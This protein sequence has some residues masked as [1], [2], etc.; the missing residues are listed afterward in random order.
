MQ[1]VFK[2]GMV[3]SRQ[4]LMTNTKRE[5][6]TYKTMFYIIKDMS[7]PK[8]FKVHD[9]LNNEME[10]LPPRHLVPYWIQKDDYLGVQD[11]IVKVLEFNHRLGEGSPFCITIEYIDGGKDKV[12]GIGVFDVDA[13]FM[14]HIQIL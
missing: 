9:I 4:M 3:V 7:D 11:C 13:N 1:Q 6:R 10:M 2:E 5:G 12:E 14:K 8:N